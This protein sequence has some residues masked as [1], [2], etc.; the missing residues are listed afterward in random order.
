[1]LAAV[2]GVGG[3]T[4][5][6]WPEVSGLSAARDDAY[7]LMVALFGSI[8]SAGGNLIAVQNHRKGMSLIPVTVCAM[9]YGAVS[10]AVYA[11]LSRQSFA[12][13]WSAPY[14]A[15]L[16]Y[17]VIFGTVVAFV[18]YLTL[19]NRIGADRASY[20]AVVIPVVALGLSTAFE[21]L[22]WHIYMVV[23]VVL[24]LCG[25]WLAHAPGARVVAEEV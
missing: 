17:L 24:C 6:F 25:N 21:D 14:L 16:L 19:Q 15:S 20:V 23:G 12:F 4:L 13:D 3:V 18:A 1:M 7:G 22:Q 5:V 10:V 11:I 9:M 8:L 2:L